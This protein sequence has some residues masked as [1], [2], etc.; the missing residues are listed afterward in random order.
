[1]VAGAPAQRILAGRM[2]ASVSVVKRLR[3][4]RTGRF[5]ASRWGAF[6]LVAVLL[7]GA[8][9]GVEL[10]GTGV[11]GRV[12][13]GGA[14]AQP[15][16]DEEIGSGPA[17]RMAESL[18][19]LSVRVERAGKT[20]R[21]KR[22]RTAF[23]SRLLPV[24]NWVGP[25][26]AVLKE[27]EPLGT[28][29]YTRPAKAE[30]VETACLWAHPVDE[31]RLVLSFAAA[32]ADGRLDLLLAYMKTAAAG[33]S[34]TISVRR[35]GV[36]LHRE[37]FTGNGGDSRRVEVSIPAKARSGNERPAPLELIIEPGKRGKNHLCLDGIVWS[38]PAA[39]GG[40]AE[41]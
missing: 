39:G 20:L 34:T 21:L 30:H 22:S 38:V 13:A 25:M 35:D 26:P 5:A 32:P 7:G 29:P 23:H 37:V 24:W 36:E 18:A 28:W 40:E 12:A 9:W 4:C 19:D 17:W 1:M 14:P 3:D 31:A 33:A 27:G 15:E 8:E 10:A 2:G 6:A 11:D 16:T 41:P